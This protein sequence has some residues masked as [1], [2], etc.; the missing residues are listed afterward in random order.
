MQVIVLGGGV[1]GV[2]SAWFLA[3]AGHQVTVIERAPEVARETSYANGGQISVCHAEPWA[4][5]KA[6]WKVLQWLG[7]EEAPL[8][9]RPRLDPAQWRWGWRFLQQC[10][11]AHARRN[12]Q[13][14]VRLGLYS[15][16]LLQQVRA[17]TGIHYDERTEGILHFYTDAAEFEAA[18]PAARLMRDAGLDRQ[19]KSATECLAIEPTLQRSMRPIVGGTYTPSDESGD[20]RRF[21]DE[22]ARLCEGLGV[23]FRYDCAIE[24]FEREGGD[25]RAVRVRGL[26]GDPA[27]SE[28]LAADAFVVCLGSY[29]PL[30][31]KSLGITL[32]IYPAKGYSATI[33]VQD[34]HQAPTVSL[35]DDG[36]KLVFSRLGNRLR[37]AGTAEFNGYNLDLNPVRCKAIVDRTREIF[38]NGSDYAAAQFWTGLRPAT[39]GN[40]PYIGG[41][42]Y[43]SLWLNTGHGTLGWTECCGSG[44]AIADLV[45]GRK[46]EVDF[47]FTPAL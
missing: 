31:L 5:P 21:T 18:I 12:L 45:S 44:K 7:D 10:T 17:E 34:H 36:H 26:N 29:S 41:T 24:G 38:P 40:L 46:P 14:L 37:V 42:R 9:F 33:P 25:V 16:E 3:K 30:H 27:G 22:L 8:L 43:P 23:V 13:N 19:V 47:P 28:R 39:P 11:A 20:A 15:R 6:P 2:T 4:G 35:T 32:D 1:I